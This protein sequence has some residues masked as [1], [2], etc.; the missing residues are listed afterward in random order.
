MSA[1]SKI[2]FEEDIERKA[3]LCTVLCTHNGS[4]WG[5]EKEGLSISRT[6]SQNKAT[7]KQNKTGNKQTNK[8]TNKKQPKRNETKTQ[9]KSKTKQTTTPQEAQT[10][11]YV[12]TNEGKDTRSKMKLVFM[13]H[14]VQKI[15]FK[16]LQNQPELPAHE[17]E[18]IRRMLKAQGRKWSRFLGWGWWGWWGW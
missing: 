4:F 2:Y 11:K 8:Q 14:T 3:Q 7:S 9:N 10:L 16:D 13:R 15:S 5:D 1:F 17:E 6:L 18:P 12:L